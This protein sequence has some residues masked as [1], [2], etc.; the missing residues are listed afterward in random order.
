M[1]LLVLPLIV[2]PIDNLSFCIGTN[3]MPACGDRIENN[4]TFTGKTQCALTQLRQPVRVTT[5]F[6]RE[7]S[8]VSHLPR[9]FVRGGHTDS[10]MDV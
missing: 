2:V 3:F 5:A 7:D 10:R 6:K 1:G 9:F 8:G 4:E